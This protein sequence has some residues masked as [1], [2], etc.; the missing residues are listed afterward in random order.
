MGQKIM[1]YQ[2]NNTE[3]DIKQK[4]SNKVSLGGR[5]ETGGSP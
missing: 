5:D 2:Q 1:E 3:T 4:D